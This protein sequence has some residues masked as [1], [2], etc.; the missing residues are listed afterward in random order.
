MEENNQD[1]PPGKKEMILKSNCFFAAG[2]EGGR[3]L[4]LD[5]VEDVSA[6]RVDPDPDVRV[7][8]REASAGR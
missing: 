7:S 3:W 6:P 4:A 2:E 1:L 8:A 5:L